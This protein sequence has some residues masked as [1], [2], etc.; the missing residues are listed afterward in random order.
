MT[1]I[2]VATDMSEARER[3]V[4]SRHLFSVSELYHENSKITLSM[5]TV[6]QSA[7]SIRVATGGFK[8]YVHAPR[9]PL[10]PPQAHQRPASL[11]A[12][13]IERRSRREYSTLPL[14]LQFVSEL[15]FFTLGTS[16]KSS[17][18]CLPSAGGLYPLELYIAALHVNGLD[19]G[20][21]HYDVRCHSLSQLQTGDCRPH[22]IKAIF[23]EEAVQTAAAVVILTGMFGRSKIKYGERAYRFVLLEAGHAMQNLC[24]AGT[25]LG[26]GVCPVGGFVDDNMNDLLDIDGVEE[27]AV[28]AAT[29]GLPPNPA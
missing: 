20:V 21:Y 11:W 3:L 16:D 13:I 6:S 24:L 4:G 2:F 18:R 28:Y 12:A 8:R 23:I 1:P 26:L 29:I 27:A 17:R 15:V 22:L 10:P 19:A 14:G 25:A 9:F 5:P 7:E